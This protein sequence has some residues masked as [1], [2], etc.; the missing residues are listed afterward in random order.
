MAWRIGKPGAREPP[1]AEENLPSDY[2]SRNFSQV[3]I[4]VNGSIFTPG[5]PYS[6]RKSLGTVCH[7]NWLSRQIY[8]YPSNHKC[9]Y[10]A[11]LDETVFFETK[12]R[13]RTISVTISRTRMRPRNIFFLVFRLTQGRE[14]CNYFQDCTPVFSRPRR[15]ILT[16]FY[17]LKTETR[18]GTLFYKTF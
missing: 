12:T 8:Q 9:E 3:I 15:E 13:T 17:L 14:F 11:A 16:P 1:L 6:V 5:I 10:K 18:P 4:S 2:F 7:E